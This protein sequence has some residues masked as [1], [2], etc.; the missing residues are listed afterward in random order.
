MRPDDRNEIVACQKCVQPLFAESVGTSPRFVED[1]YTINVAR[2][3]V[4]GVCPHQVAERTL[5]WNFCYAI[6]PIYVLESFDVRRYA[7]VHAHKVVIHNC[8]YWQRIKTVHKLVLG[9]SVEFI[10]AFH[11]EI[12]ERCNFPALVIAAQKLDISRLVYFQ[13]YQK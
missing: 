3:V 11:K 5:A 7:T 2:L 6:D 12:E 4:D 10:V 13:G 1:P 8:C 9:F